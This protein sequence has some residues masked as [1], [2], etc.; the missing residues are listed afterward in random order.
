MEMWE[1]MKSYDPPENTGVMFNSN[2]IVLSI[3][4]KISENYNN[5][6]SGSSIA[7]TMRKMQQIA[8]ENT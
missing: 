3:M 8:K 7:C 6:H 5:N 4:M 2:P 1:F